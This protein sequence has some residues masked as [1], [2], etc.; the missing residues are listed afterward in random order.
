MKKIIHIPLRILRFALFVIF[1]FKEL[2]MSSLLLARDIIRPRHTFTH[3]IIAI[4]IDLKNDTSIITLANLLSMTP[5][6]LTVD[7]S[8]DKKRLYIHSMYLEDPEKF[9]RKV[10]NSFEKAIKQIFE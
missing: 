8:P 10:K 1:Y 3:G 6:S 5:G 7:L 2:F 9:K 4:D